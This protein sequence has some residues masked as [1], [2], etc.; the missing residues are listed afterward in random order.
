MLGLPFALFW[1][2][3]WVVLTAAIM[4]RGLRD[5]PPEGSPMNAAL[6]IIAGF[7]GLAI[8]LGAALAARARHGP[9]AV[10]GR[11]PRLRDDL[12]LP[13]DGGRDLLDLHVP[14]RRR[15][16]RT[17]PAARPTTSSA[18]ARSPTCCRTTCCPRSGAT[19]RRASSSR[20][21]TSSRARSTR[22]ALGVV[23][24]RRR[25]GG[26][27]PLPRAA[28]EGPRDH[29]L[30]DLLRLDLLDRGDLDGRARALALRRRVGHPRLG[31]DGG[32]QGRA[33]ARRSCVFIGLY[34]PI[35]YFG[36]DRRDVPRD[37]RRQA[38]LPDAV[39]AASSRRS[40]SPR[41]CC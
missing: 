32:D 10:D 35:H 28:A 9:R 26:D 29:R 5:R 41:P 12:R 6:A 1:V 22:A 18:T 30:A 16:S 25:R 13:A 40:G 39:R 2:V 20:R 7:V 37:R 27:D 21:P 34:L 14:R 31:V 4:A 11:R 17:A 15:A 3:L 8:G 33:D 23:V 36:G 38:R 24:S 19:R